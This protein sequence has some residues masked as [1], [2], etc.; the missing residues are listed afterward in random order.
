VRTIINISPTSKHHLQA[1][2]SSKM[3]FSQ[4]FIV[5]VSASLLQL[6]IASPLQ[7]R[8]SSEGVYLS[9]CDE[10]EPGKLF[11]QMDYYS[12]AK[13]G[14]QNSEKPD[15]T[16]SV[17]DSSGTVN[18]EGQ[19]VCGTFTGGETFCSSIVEN[20]QSLVS[21]ELSS[22][23]SYI[24]KGLLNANGNIRLPVIMPE[25]LTTMRLASAV[26]KITGEFFIL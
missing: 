5:L 3:Y 1:R 9:N 10:F 2:Q 6:A 16:A 4:S 24:R 18:W 15:A 7:T 11:S 20:G 22:L 25:T 21:G 8:D 14:S 19:Q 13:G 12:N 23:S 17:G 26:T